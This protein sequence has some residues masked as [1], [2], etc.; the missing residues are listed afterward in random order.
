MLQSKLIQKFERRLKAQR[1]SVNTF[2]NFS[3][4]LK[5]ALKEM[6]QSGVKALPLELIERYINYKITEPNISHS[7][8]RNIYACN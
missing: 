2:S 7:Y 6:K 3:N 4:V 5:M 8:Q 1:F